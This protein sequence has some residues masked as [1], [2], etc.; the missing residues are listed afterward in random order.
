MLPHW[1]GRQ[2]AA[3][4]ED[5][6]VPFCTRDSHIEPL[7]RVDES[8]RGQQ[9]TKYTEHIRGA[10]EILITSNVR[11]PTRAFKSEPRPHP[12]PPVR[13]VLTMTISFSDP[14]NA[15]T[16]EHAKSDAESSEDPEALAASSSLMRYAWALSAPTMHIHHNPQYAMAKHIRAIWKRKKQKW[17]NERPHSSMG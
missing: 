3:I 1:I 4:A 10:N 15:S 16:V 7:R 12:S 14:W 8:E 5:H 11:S 9:H 6:K 2:I 17:L 13:T